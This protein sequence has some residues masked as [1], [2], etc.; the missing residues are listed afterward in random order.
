M[1]QGYSSSEAC[2]IVGINVPTGKRWRNGWHSPPTGKPKPPITAEVP[3]CEPSR[4][5]LAGVLSGVRGEWVRC[6]RSP[7]TGRGR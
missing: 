1:Q 3:A 5:G 2:R 7:G 4:P 6:L